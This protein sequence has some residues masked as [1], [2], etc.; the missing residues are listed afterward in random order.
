MDNAAAKGVPWKYAQPIYDPY[1]RVIVDP[2]G[3]K[4]IQA[5]RYR[6]AVPP[7]GAAP[8]HAGW[9]YTSSRGP[10]PRHLAHGRRSAVGVQ[11]DASRMKPASHSTWVVTRMMTEW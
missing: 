9:V 8:A 7:R 2:Y 4:S 3:S 11:A 6:R 5:H 10:T 1:S